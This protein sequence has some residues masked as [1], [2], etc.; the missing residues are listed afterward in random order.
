MKIPPS[1]FEAANMLSSRNSKRSLYDSDIVYHDI[2]GRRYCADYYMPCDEDEIIRMEI[3]HVVYEYT[4]AGKFTTAPLHSPTRILDVGTGRGDWAIAMG[5]EYPEAEVTGTDIAKIQP[6]AVPMNVF[7]EIWD[8]EEEYGW[9]LAEDSF[10]LVHFRTMRGAFKNW[11]N[12]Y[13]ESFKALKPGSWIEVLDF[14]DHKAMLSFFPPGGVTAP[15]LQAIDEGS[16]IAGTPRGI[17]HLEHERFTEAGFVDVTTEEHI[18]PLG[19]WP[20]EP[21]ERRIAKLFMIAQMCGI[22][23]LCLR[24]LTEQMG[25]G[26]SEIRKICDIV[27]TEMRIA[28]LDPERARGLGFLVRVVKGRKP[29]LEELESATGSTS[30]LRNGIQARMAGKSHLGN[31][32]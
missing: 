6:S 11:S 31:D 28:C 26:L 15:W 8:A 14:D 13:K 19:T 17:K 16:R 5:E 21:D 29:T 27:T 10:D 30:T 32:V 7:F 18:I 20:T 2:H 23:A 12:I 3:L 9:T 24:V 4:L 25:W 1:C 22:E